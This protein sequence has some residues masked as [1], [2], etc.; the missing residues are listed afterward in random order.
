MMPR[1]MPR[2]NLWCPEE[3]GSHPGVNNLKSLYQSRK[4]DCLDERTDE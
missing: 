1:W 3:K 4:V 2:E